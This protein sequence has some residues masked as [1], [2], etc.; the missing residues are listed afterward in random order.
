LSDEEYVHNARMVAGGVDNASRILLA[1][2]TQY[3]KVPI[4]TL[5]LNQSETQAPCLQGL[6]NKLAFE[7]D[8][9][10]S[11]NLVQQDFNGALVAPVNEQAFFTTLPY[12]VD[13]RLGIEYV[14]VT[15]SERDA[16]VALYR[17]RKGLRYLINEVQRPP[18]QVIPQAT[19]SNTGQTI[20][21]QVLNV[22]QPVYAAAWLLRWQA[23]LTASYLAAQTNAVYG[24][25]WFNCNGWLQPAGTTLP[26]RP[27]FNN[28]AMKSGNN[29]LIYQGSIWD[30]LDDK[31]GRYF[32]NGAATVRGI[33]TI[34]YAHRPTAANACT[35]S[36]DWSVVNQPIQFWQFGSGAYATIALWATQDIGFV[37]D[38]VVAGIF[39]TYN[40]IDVTN[41]DAIRPFN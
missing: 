9:E 16:V 6:G 31:S 35:G 41:Y 23:D 40:N 12:G 8:F 19:A 2:Q 34:S 7:V 3:L 22:N 27:M 37:S 17:S 1:S 18:D 33:P 36:V 28:M 29:N 20:S 4:H 30:F 15:T 5:F 26:L 39:F 14:H 38:L 32:K 13:C 25:N 21:W 24:R 11:V 10:P